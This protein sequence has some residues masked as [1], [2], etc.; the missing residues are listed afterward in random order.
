MWIRIPVFLAA[1]VMMA[2]AAQQSAGALVLVNSQAPDYTEFARVIEPY[3]VQFG[4]PYEV[5]DVARQRAGA[6]LSGYALVVIGHR[7]LD[8][9]RRFFTDEDDNALLAAVRGGT[10]LV[11]F[12]GLLATWKGR[13]SQNIYGF[14]R[15]IFGLTPRPGESAASVKVESASHFI[16][17]GGA[18]TLKLKRTMP[19]PGFT[20]GEKARVVASAG[21]QP[22]VVA[23]E[24]G[25]GRAV[26]FSSYDWSRP[27]VL[28]KLYGLDDL[29]W[30]SLV[31]AARKPFVMRRMPPYL[32]FRVDDVSGF[33][34]GSNQHLGWVEVANKYG[35]RPWLGIFIDDMREDQQATAT[36][37]RLSQKGLVTASP[38][39]RRWSEFL[40]LNEPLATD[41]RQRNIA[42]KPWPDEQM[43]ANWAE[44]EAFWKQHGIAK[45]K[46]VLPHF[47]EFAL[48]DFEGMKRWGAEFTGTVLKPGL[49]Y[50]TEVP[51]SAPYL[52]GEPVRISSGGDPIY[53]SDWLEV[54][55]F[56]KQFF[57]LVVEVR[58]V[59]GYEW[60]P[61][62]VTVEEAIRRGFEETRREFDSLVPAVL[63]THESDHIR[64]IT[65]EN[66]EA[67][68]R[69]VMER[70]APYHPIPVTL[71]FA[72]QYAR[73]LRT[74]KLVA[75]GDGTARLIGTA[76]IA[77]KLYLYDSLEA[78]EIEVPPF[79]GIKV[80]RL[81]PSHR[82]L[83][84]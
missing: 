81:Q 41:D 71:D 25:S 37:A 6:G 65:P 72:T 49:G 57:N 55:G 78:R 56:E 3:F 74:S 23:V 75:A 58:D 43:A 70:L 84:P 51:A 44:A 19:V 10:G 21:Q 15:E 35:L 4:V 9:P 2:S 53:I 26:L 7:G 64:K 40:F 1:A 18:R 83:L 17:A 24:Q 36:L 20:A 67:I 48:N 28:G 69:G 39:A 54:P 16:A 76:D 12:D 30:R 68:V 5:R 13:R 73:A 45:A 8:A 61:S 62:G 33:G 38:H 22:L 79:R 14:A 47:Y 66:W 63:F 32:A 11:S 60:A 29:V 80:V 27:D 59:A 34:I 50:G 77:T 46:V 52:S 31:W 82:P 42:G